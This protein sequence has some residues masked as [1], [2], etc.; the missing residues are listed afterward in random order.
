VFIG[1]LCGAA[2]WPLLTAL[3]VWVDDTNFSDGPL[4]ALTIP[5]IAVYSLLS[6]PFTLLGPGY[7]GFALVV[8]IWAA[9]GAMIGRW[10]ASRHERKR[11][12]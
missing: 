3:V 4:L 1:T 2:L 6:I 9:A 8:A 7:L 5:L 11:S 12:R 10:L